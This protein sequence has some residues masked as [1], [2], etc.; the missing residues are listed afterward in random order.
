MKAALRHA[1]TRIPINDAWIAS[2]CLEHGA[3]L[4]TRNRHFRHIPGLRLGLTRD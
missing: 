2:Q 4:L 3:V 1:G